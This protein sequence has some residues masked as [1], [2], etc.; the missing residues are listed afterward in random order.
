MKKSWGGRGENSETKDKPD[1]TF[2]N[3]MDMMM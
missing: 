2:L 1:K 3:K